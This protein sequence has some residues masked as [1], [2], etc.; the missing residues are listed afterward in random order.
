MSIPSPSGDTVLKQIQLQRLQ[1]RRI[2]CGLTNTLVCVSDEHNADLYYQK[3]A[4][5]V[6]FTHLPAFTG[7]IKDTAGEFET[8]I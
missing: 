5:S 4:L 2:V 6:K 7:P 3:E 8:E 1:C